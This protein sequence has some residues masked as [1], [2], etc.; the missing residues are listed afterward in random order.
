MRRLLIFTILLLGL[1]NLILSCHGQDHADTSAPMTFP[2]KVRQQLPLWFTD[3]L[4]QFERPELAQ[5]TADLE[6][7]DSATDSATR[8]ALESMLRDDWNRLELKD[9]QLHSMRIA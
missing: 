9:E 8:D 6:L 4:G 5:V 1:V 3:G 7:Y 2:D